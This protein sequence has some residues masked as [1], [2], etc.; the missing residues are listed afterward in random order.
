[1]L[2]TVMVPCPK[3]GV[4]FPAT[5]NSGLCN[6][7]TYSFHD[8][9]DDTVNGVNYHAPFICNG[10]ETKFMVKHYGKNVNRTVEWTPEFEKE[11]WP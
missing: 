10:C 4:L 7:T 8:V 3:C 11:G 1:M 2:D 6:G 9:P 5:S